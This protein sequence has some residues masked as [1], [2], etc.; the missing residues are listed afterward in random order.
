MARGCTAP[1]PG[2]GVGKGLG[3]GLGF[4]WEPGNLVCGLD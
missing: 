3:L 1:A 2:G 4:P